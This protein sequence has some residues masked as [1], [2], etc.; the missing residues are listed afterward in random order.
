[1]D[2]TQEQFFSELYIKHAKK[3]VWFA[4]RSIGDEQ[5]AED[6]MQETFLLA[7]AKIQV[8]FSHPNPEGWL[9]KTLNN[10]ILRDMNKKYHTELPLDESIEFDMENEFVFF[11]EC[12]PAGLSDGEKQMLIWRF[13]YQL[14][15]DEIAELL[16]ITQLAS[17]KRLSRIIKECSL[18]LNTEK[19]FKKDVTELPPQEI[20]EQ[21]VMK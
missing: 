13:K 5:L 3:M 16:G 20:K 15:H 12:L 21:E 9:Y 10:L 14:S 18:L 8:V 1:M 4:Y 17:R 19:N 11:D 2:I 6:L 7:A